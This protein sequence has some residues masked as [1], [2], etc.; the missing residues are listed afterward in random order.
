M[1]DTAKRTADALTEK[2]LAQGAY[3][4]FRDAYRARLRWLKDNRPH[5]FG[6]ALDHYND[7]LVPNIANGAEPV[8]EWIHY[9]KRLAELT[10]RGKFVQVDATGR[11]FE[12]SEEFDGLLLHLPDDTAAPALALAIPRELSEAQQ[13]TLDLLVKNR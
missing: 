5:D 8:A 9:G 11:A 2:A 12:L 6:R 3:A 13:A 1:D 10:G 7:L 4:D